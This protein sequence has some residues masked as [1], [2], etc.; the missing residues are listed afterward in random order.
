MVRRARGETRED[1]RPGTAHGSGSGSMTVKIRPL[2]GQRE[3]LCTLG[4]GY[5]ATAGGGSRGGR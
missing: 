1:L 4:N 3:A 2:E 5:F